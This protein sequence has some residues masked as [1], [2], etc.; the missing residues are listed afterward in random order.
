MEK[1]YLSSWEYN[2]SMILDYIKQLVEEEG[3]RLVTTW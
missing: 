3:G 1:R 2:C